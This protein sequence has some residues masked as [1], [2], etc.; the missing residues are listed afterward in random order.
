MQK[1][2]IFREGG[3]WKIW[4]LQLGRD[5]AGFIRGSHNG[6]FMPVRNRIENWR[7][8]LGGTLGPEGTDQPRGGRAEE[9]NAKEPE[10]AGTLPSTG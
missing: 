2:L 8:P 9:G 3:M 4:P 7:I 10:M 1:E 5:V 6:P